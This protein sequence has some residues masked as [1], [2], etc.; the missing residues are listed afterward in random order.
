[1][2]NLI[3]LPEEENALRIGKLRAAASVTLPEN[4]R[5]EDAALL[6]A[7]NA[8]VYYLTGRVFSTL[9]CDTS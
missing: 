3:L 7:D 5:E 8:T 6:I 1:M 9:I 4:T 2:E